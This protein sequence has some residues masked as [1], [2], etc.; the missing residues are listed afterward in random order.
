[1]ATTLQIN[2]APTDL[3]HIIH[4][5][6][7]QFRQ[8]GGQ[9]DEILLTLDLHQSR[10]RFGTGWKERLP[11]F[12]NFVEMQSLA[13]AKIRVHEVDYSRSAVRTIGERF[14]GGALIPPKDCNGG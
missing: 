9:V 2:L 14:F 13:N 7:H 4:I 12:L 1:M 11:G 3:P 5:L 10:G 8:L 6:P